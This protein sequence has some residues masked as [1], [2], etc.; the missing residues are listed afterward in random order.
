MQDDQSVPIS[1]ASLHSMYM[2]VALHLYTAPNGSGG[3]IAVMII[4]IHSSYNP[5]RLGPR[6][7]QDTE[8]QMSDSTSQRQQ[9]TQ[10]PHRGRLRIEY[11]AYRS[12]DY[13]VPD[14]GLEM[15]HRIVRPVIVVDIRWV[16]HQSLSFI[17]TF[18]FEVDDL[19]LELCQSISWASPVGRDPTH[20][21]DVSTSV[22]VHS[23][24]PISLIYHTARFN[25][26][27][28]LK[29]ALFKKEHS[30]QRPSLFNFVNL[31]HATPRDQAGKC[32]ADKKEC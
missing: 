7:R 26:V 20:F 29:R 3:A 1:D 22:R 8:I 4:S 17:W 24:G 31:H 16:I 28:D 15:S 2:I 13:D 25:R 14:T 12:S 27:V 10:S 9:G 11:I 19:C 23:V 6:N 30:S 18:R 5:E 32:S 21:S